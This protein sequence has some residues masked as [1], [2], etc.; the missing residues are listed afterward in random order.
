MYRLISL[1][2]VTDGG[3]NNDTMTRVVVVGGKSNYDSKTKAMM[4]VYIM[5]TNCYKDCKPP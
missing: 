4:G 5:C 3:V 2:E 1:L